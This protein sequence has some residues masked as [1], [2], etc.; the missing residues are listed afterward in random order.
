MWFIRVH[1]P[2][3]PYDLGYLRDRLLILLFWLI[4]RI[5]LIRCIALTPFASV[6]FS[7]RYI[8]RVLILLET[9]SFVY[10]FSLSRS[11]AFQWF[12][13]GLSF[14]FTLPA[15]SSSGIYL[16]LTKHAGIIP[17]RFNIYP[18][19]IF[20][21]SATVHHVRRIPRK[22][23]PLQISPFAYFSLLISFIKDIFLIWF[24]HALAFFLSE[25]IPMFNLL[26]CLNQ[27]YSD[28]TF[29]LSSFAFIRDR[30]LFIHIPWSRHLELPSFIFLIR[31]ISFLLLLSYSSPF[32]V[33]LYT[34]TFR[35]RLHRFF[36]I[37]PICLKSFSFLA[38][39]GFTIGFLF[40]AA[41]LF[42]R[43][44]FT[45]SRRRL[46]CSSVLI[47]SGLF[48]F[49]YLSALLQPRFIH[50]RTPS[51][52]SHTFWNLSFSIYVFPRGE[53]SSFSLLFTISGCVTFHLLFPITL[54]L[55]HLS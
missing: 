29:L 55:I 1:G 21:D 50:E 43:A 18:S 25:V 47:F 15:L 52:L 37:F 44:R 53:S 4:L 36:R 8:S 7:Q 28:E 31:V 33:G 10:I 17:Y 9:I 22:F 54:V 49:L 39:I 24:L 41:F 32:E 23:C 51:L 6:S 2:V 38:V 40:P 16:L 35:H 12:P 13:T 45:S 30:S 14:Y 42:G 5:Y 19:F 34:N 46:K 20:V 26:L 11:H 48:Y 27:L 3:R